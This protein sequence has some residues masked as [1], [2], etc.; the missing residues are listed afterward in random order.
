[1]FQGTNGYFHM[2]KIRN[3]L[4]E[5]H[6]MKRFGDKITR[7]WMLAKYTC[8]VRQIGRARR[9]SIQVRSIVN[10]EARIT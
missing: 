8:Y 7:I 2:D 9:N 6:G 3:A 4:G 5:M 1:M 10:L